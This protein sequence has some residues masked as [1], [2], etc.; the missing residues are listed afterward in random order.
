[1][2]EYA[3]SIKV[4]QNMVQRV[5]MV[6]YFQSDLTDGAGLTSTYL[7]HLAPL[8]LGH[9]QAT[10]RAIPTPL[11]LTACQPSASL[12]TV[13]PLPARSALAHYNSFTS[14]L[15]DVLPCLACV[16]LLT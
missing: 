13:C 14:A 7:L 8:A 2:Q 1:M 5:A 11:Y 12:A 6:R 15:A 9:T 16:H 10:W 4:C 3:E